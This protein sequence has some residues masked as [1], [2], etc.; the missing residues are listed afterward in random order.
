[1]T[2]T[3]ERS[4]PTGGAGTWHEVRRTAPWLLGGGV[5]VYLLLAGAGLAIT[6]LPEGTAV[7]RLDR[8][9]TA[10]AVGERTAAMD[11]WTHRFSMLSD[12]TTAWLVTAVCVVL[13]SL[14]LRRRREPVTVLLAICGELFIFLLV[15]ATVHRQRPDVPRLDGAPPTSSFPSGHTGAAVA[16]YGGL[17]VVLL[18]VTRFRAW[19]VVAAV[20]LWVVPVLVAVARVYRGMH[21]LSDVVAGALAGGLWLAIV[22]RTVRPGRAPDRRRTLH[23]EPSGMV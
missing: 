13:L 9:V 7:L 21:F 16:L 8:R 18:L 1:M 11:V 5:L 19:A 14:W 15:T 20:L 10:W 22:V 17:A 3:R 4:R 12:T 6:R 2:I 23:R